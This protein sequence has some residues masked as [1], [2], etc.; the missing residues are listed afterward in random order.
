MALFVTLRDRGER[1]ALDKESPLAYVLSLTN[2]IE[3]IEAEIWGAKVSMA[4]L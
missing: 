3:L 1:N 2:Q 4:S